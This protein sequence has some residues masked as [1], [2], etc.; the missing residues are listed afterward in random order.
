MEY[1]TQERKAGYRKQLNLYK[2]KTYMCR[3]RVNQHLT[4]LNLYKVS[5]NKHLVTEFTIA[6]VSQNLNLM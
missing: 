6:K 1:E 3:F 5:I 2:A 4:V